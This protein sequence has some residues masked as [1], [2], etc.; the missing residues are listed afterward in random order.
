M[1]QAAVGTLTLEAHQEFAA[2]VSGDGLI[3]A[4]DAI[5]ILEYVAG[6]RP[7]MPEAEIAQA[8]DSNRP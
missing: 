7:N 8:E 1:L 3:T 5:L 6:L 4:Y 2:D